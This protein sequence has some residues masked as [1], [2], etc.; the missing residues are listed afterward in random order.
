[1]IILN[2]ILKH[3][4]IYQVLSLCGIAAPVL[5]FCAVLIA[6]SL[7]PNYSH[8]SQAIS[9][10]GAQGAPYKIILNFLG[11]IPSGLLTLLFSLAML[12]II[13]GNSALY[14][15]CAFVALAGLGRLFAGFFPC[16]PGCIPI[17]SISGKL[18]AI[19]GGIALFAGSIA[20]LMMAIGLRKQHYRVMYYISLVLGIASILVFMALTSQ[21][22]MP[23]FGLMQRMLLILT[24]VW[25]IVV[26]I[27]IGAV[28]N[29]GSKLQ[30]YQD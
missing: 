29:K 8:V 5:L 25:M 6:G 18:H 4:L 23:Y 14:I 1:M 16:D 2:K 27:S 24:Y 17:I 20:P 15:S 9:V 30:I 26:A 22:M 3:K 7:H 13:K 11:L 12:Q 21:I 10:L 19:F 28:S